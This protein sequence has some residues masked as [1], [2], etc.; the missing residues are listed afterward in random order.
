MFADITLPIPFDSFTYLVPS[1]MESRVMRGCRVV[2]SLGKNKIYT[3]VVLRTH[4]NAPQ[5]VEIKPI[6]EVL[7]EH[8]VV[9]EL[10]FKF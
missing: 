1:D 8:P 10:Q 7:D 5:G 3:G 6:L 9:N 4:D 2:V